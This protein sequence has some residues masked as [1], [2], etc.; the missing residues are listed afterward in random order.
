MAPSAAPVEVATFRNE[1][2]R[3]AAVV[4][5]LVGLVAANIGNGFALNQLAYAFLFAGLATG[6]NVIGGLG[7]QFSL[8]HGVFL[9]IGAYVT[10]NLYINFGVS[11]WLALIPA[12]ALSAAAAVVISSRS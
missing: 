9:A 8:A 1:T 12:A 3:L 4:L 11:P 5:A 2:P 6:W 10:A 7:G